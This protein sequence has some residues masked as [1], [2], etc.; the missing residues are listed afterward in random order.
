MG[1]GSVYITSGRDV[2]GESGSVSG[3]EGSK[4]KN[5]VCICDG[6]SELIKV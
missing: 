3:F 5:Q 1:V 6:I 2:K 4:I